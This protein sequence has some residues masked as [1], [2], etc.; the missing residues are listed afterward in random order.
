M[1]VAIGYAVYAVMQLAVLAGCIVA[2]LRAPQPAAE[3]LERAELRS[4]S[5]P[6]G[7]DG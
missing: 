4:S 6:T 3:E 1:I 5:W 7:Y 2:W